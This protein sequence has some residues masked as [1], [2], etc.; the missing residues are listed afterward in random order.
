MEADPYEDFLK[1]LLSKE[2]ANIAFSKEVLNGNP[3]CAAKIGMVEAMSLMHYFQHSEPRTYSGVGNLMFVNAGIFPPE[4]K[5]F[6]EFNEEYL[7][8]I[9]DLD[10]FGMWIFG[11]EPQGVTEKN[12]FTD[13]AKNAVIVKAG[14]WD[15]F[16]YKDPWTKELKGKKALV[17]SPF[18]ET[19]E[20]QYKKRELLWEN[21]NILPEF[22][23]L[24]TIQCP[25]SAGMVG[26]SPFPSWKDGLNKIKENMEKI[27]FDVCFVGAGAWGLPLAV[28]AK[29][30]GK[31]GIHSAGDTQLIFGIKGKRWDDNP[32][33]GGA[34]YNEHWVRPSKDETPQNNSFIEGGCYW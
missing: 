11:P 1:A 23:S 27:D 33:R 19:I 16:H 26:E 3:F 34:Y 5:S 24:N 28:H 22:E 14:S 4:A 21:P 15:P 13:Y 2:E 25:M 6:D 32:G 10:F 8:H 29:R 9:K 18:A 31:I 17:I 7:D 20:K 12:V 30:M